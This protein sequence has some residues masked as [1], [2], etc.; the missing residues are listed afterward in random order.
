MT[1]ALAPNGAVPLEPPSAEPA[2]GLVGPW[3][4]NRGDELMLEA[5]FRRFGG[6]RLAIPVELWPGGRP[7]GNVRPVALP[8]EAGEARLALG[9]RDGGRLLTLAAKAVAMRLPGPVLERLT[10]HGDAR[11]LDVLLDCSGFAYGDDWSVGRMERRA[12]YY[13]TL[14][15]EGTRIVM[16][17]QAFGPF[18][19]PD[20][21][22]AARRLL[23][24]CTLAVARDADSLEHLRA[25]ELPG[26]APRLARAP[27]I[28]HLLDATPPDDAEA[29]GRRAVIVPNARMIDRTS[30]ARAVAY[31][32]F[33][34]EAIAACA[35]A[36]LEPW[37][38]LHEDNDRAMVGEV[39]ERAGG[40]NV[41]DGGGLRLKGA[42]GS[43][44]LVIASRYHAIVSAL[45][46]GVP[47][48][49]TSW[50]H[51]Y[52]RLFEEYGHSDYLLA[53]ES[54]PALLRARC[55]HLASPEGQAEIRARLRDKAA[56]QRAVVEA[57]WDDVEG[58]IA[59]R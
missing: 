36:G 12:A 31:E 57:M 55:T 32:T 28:T 7:G 38:M 17:P 6:T 25:L 3:V 10:G 50:S 15:A 48:I 9:R 26:D 54:D 23:A 11:G 42:I 8:P 34:Q 33:L 45:S 19:R 52:V 39:S 56:A 41:L 4:A 40:L 21:R 30:G 46:Q 43:A 20:V 14:K 51:K 53:P 49:G 58:V 27:D 24:T 18:E 44:R 2:I 29:W 59:R 37:L 5:V 35:S 16:L 1:D 47:A 13:G 22:D